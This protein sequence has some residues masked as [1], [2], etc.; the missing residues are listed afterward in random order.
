VERRIADAV[1]KAMTKLLKPYWC[2]VHT[3]TSDNDKEFAG[4]DMTSISGRETSTRRAGLATLEAGN[5][6]VP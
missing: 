4:H 2:R 1:S 3:I 6:S 5:R